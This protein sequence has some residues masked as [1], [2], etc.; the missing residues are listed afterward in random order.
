MRIHLSRH[1]LTLIA[2]CLTALVFSEVFGYDTVSGNTF[3]ESTVADAAGFEYT[4]LSDGTASITKCT[5]SGDIVIPSS[6]DGY[7]VTNLAAELF[8]GNTNITSVSVPATVTYFGDD[9]S[10]NMWDYVFSYCYSLRAINV[11]SGNPSFRS[12]DGVLYSKDMSTLFNY[13]CMRQGSEYTTPDS[14]DWLCCTSFASAQNLTRL[15]IDNPDAG[16]ATYTFYNCGGLTVYYHKDGYSQTCAENHIRAGLSH[17]TNKNYPTYRALE[18]S[19]VPTAPSADPSTPATT[20]PVVTPE[21][22]YSSDP[23]TAPKPTATTA[24]GP[25]LGTPIMTDDAE[26]EVTA[27]GEVTYKA[28]LRSKAKV[29]IPETI[30]SGSVVLKV[31]G[32][33]DRAFMNDKKLITV[34]IGKNIEI[35]GAN[36]FASCAKLTSVKGGTAVKMINDKA[37]KSCVKLKKF[38]IGVNVDSIGK[39]AFSGCKALKIITVKTTLLSADNVGKAAFKGINKKATVK[40]PK[41]NLKAY[42]KLFVKKGAPKSCKFK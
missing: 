4:V 3:A 41:A 33:A 19:P 20:E 27:P 29:K 42:K 25:A 13:P 38:T 12:V 6:I 5:L 16:W 28:P 35:I 17:E 23:T 9:P 11:E 24:P 36:A 10:D 39:S 37:F 7:K 1:I 31:T 15:I 34:T 32:I 40:C 22:T 8:F 14:L 2:A 26:Y 18:S 21:P 30:E